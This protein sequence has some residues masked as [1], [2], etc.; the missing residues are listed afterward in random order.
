MAHGIAG[1]HNAIPAAY[2]LFFA[3]VLISHDDHHTRVCPTYSFLFFPVFLDLHYLRQDIVLIPYHFALTGCFLLLVPR[4]Q[5]CIH[6]SMIPRS[7][8]AV[9]ASAALALAQDNVYGN[10]AAQNSTHPTTKEGDITIHYVYVGKATNNF[11]VRNFKQLSCFTSTDIPR[12]Q[13]VSEPNRVTSSPSNSFHRTTQSLEQRTDIL[14]FLLIMPHPA[15]TLS[16]QVSSQHR[17]SQTL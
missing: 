12:S 6:S 10:T 5:T 16:T 13:I 14:A 2:F 9:A 3:A 1:R 11:Y 15:D 7:L 4:I 8:A 17:R